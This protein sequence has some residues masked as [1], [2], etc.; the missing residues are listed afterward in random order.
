MTSDPPAEQREEFDSLGTVMVPANHYWGAQTQR[1]LQHFAIDDTRMPIEVYRAYG[2]VKKA[3]AV[4]NAERLPHADLIQRVC[5]EVIAGDL[6]DEFPLYVWQSGSGTHTN[7]NVNEVIANRCIELAGGALGSQ[8]P[9]S[10][11]DHVNMSQS[12]N[13]TFPT[14]MHVATYTMLVEQTLP[15]LRLLRDALSHKAEQWADIRKVG[16]THLQ[17]ATLL[18]VG[19]EWSGYAS[20]LDDAIGDLERAAAELLPVALGGTA[21]GTG[22]NAPPDFAAQAVGVLAELTGY[23]FVPAPNPFAALATSDR[24]VRAHAALKGVA[25]TLFKIG[26]DLRWLGSGP[27]AGLAELRLPANEP[28]SS[29]MPGKVNPSQAEALLM[30]CTEVMGA[31]VTVQ[32]CGAEGNFELNTFRPLLVWHCLQSARLLGGMSDHFRRFLVEGADLNRERLQRDVENSVMVVTA[33]A[34][35]IGYH[36]AA[37]IAHRAVA[38]DLALR[39]VALEAGVSPELF[40]EVIRA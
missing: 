17:D 39:D 7:M 36:E 10:P 38:E 8:Q 40:D 18:T 3:C 21:V 35:H 4:V 31:D 27:R 28:G 5:D 37:R 1:S 19:Q 2:Y 20:A 9:V 25:V 30:V 6:D 15:S 32:M 26:N 33:L 29:I 34:P 13:D 23:S 16:R 12:S 11:N 14:V 22:L 24:V